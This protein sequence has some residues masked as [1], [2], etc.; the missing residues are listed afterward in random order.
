[1]KSLVGHGITCATKYAMYSWWEYLLDLNVL[2]RSCIALNKQY[3]SPPDFFSQI[4]TDKPTH[5]GHFQ[6]RAP[7]QRDISGGAGA[8][9]C[10]VDTAQAMQPPN[11]EAQDVGQH[12]SS[13]S[14]CI[15]SD[16]DMSAA[17]N[18]PHVSDS[19]VWYVKPQ[20]VW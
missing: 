14:A 10:T 1:M 2:D 20:G 19:D 5:A 6:Q 4:A 18:P 17:H 12:N 11:T 13:S 9:A 7:I 3:C 15:E 8:L 16:V